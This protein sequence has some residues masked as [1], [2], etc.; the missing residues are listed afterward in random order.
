MI[1]ARVKFKEGAIP[2]FIANNG[3]NA[4]L[5]HHLRTEHMDSEGVF[6]ISRPNENTVWRL[7][8]SNGTDG[9]YFYTEEINRFFDFVSPVTTEVKPDKP[10]V[11]IVKEIFLGGFVINKDNAVEIKNLIE[12]TFNV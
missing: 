11:R 10:G 12:E 5:L 2:G 6:V 9:W 1:I 3:Y 8:N 7:S 4:T